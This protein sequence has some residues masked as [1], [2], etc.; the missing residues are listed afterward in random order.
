MLAHRQSSLLNAAEFAR[1][2]GVDGKTVASYLDLLADLLLVRRLAP[3]HANVGKRLV[4]SPRIY[5]RDSGIAHSLLGI[6]SM[7]DLLGH[8]IAGASWEGF[9]IETL[10]AAA[11]QGTKASF[12]RTAAGAEVDLALTLPGGRVWAVEIQ[13]SLTP[14]AEKGFHVARQDLDPERAYVVYPGSEAY[15]LGEGIIAVGLQDLGRE[16][17]RLA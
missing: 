15:P 2:L 11:P 5:V 16:L 14:R 8:P 3:W 12:Y 6:T 4:K 13:R 1:G 17:A 9:V 7:E 10:I